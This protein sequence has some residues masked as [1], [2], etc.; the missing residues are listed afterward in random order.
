MI[1]LPDWTVLPHTRRKLQPIVH[2]VSQEVGLPM[3]VWIGRDQSNRAV[4][5]WTNP[6]GEQRWIHARTEDD[7]RVLVSQFFSDK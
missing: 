1:Q 4:I 3:R 6:W 2:A 7:A 5:K